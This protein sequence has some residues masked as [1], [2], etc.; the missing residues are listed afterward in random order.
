MPSYVKIGTTTRSIEMRMRDL[1]TTGLP[2]PFECHYA[3]V[4]DVNKNVEKRIHR[5]FDTFRVNK[6]REFFEIEADAAADIIRLVEIKDVTPTESIVETSD[7]NEAISRLEK[8]A[9][10]FS[11]KMVGI[12]PETILTFK[13]DET[14]TC[15]VIDNRR[16]EFND[17]VTSLS[18]AALLALR[19][20][21]F[22]WKSAQGA[23]YWML[24][25]KSLKDLRD[26]IENE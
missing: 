13:L 23:A 6:N 21:G 4:V 3:A 14:V 1:Y 20:A 9:E 12:D 15:K 26:D 11:F 17:E 5:A 2:V 19:H 10:R 7:D 25:G 16:V 18:A 8:R 24:N 22:D